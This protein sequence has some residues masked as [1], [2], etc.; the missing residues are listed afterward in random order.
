MVSVCSHAF[1]KRLVKKQGLLLLRQ[2]A[3]L[4]ISERVDKQRALL[5]LS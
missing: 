4:V 1:N 3:L 2:A 5:S